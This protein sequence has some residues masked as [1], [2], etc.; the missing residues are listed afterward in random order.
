MALKC[1][2]V[3]NE[4]KAPTEVKNGE[5]RIL[6]RDE[7]VDAHKQAVAN[8]M[9]CL[10]REE[11]GRVEHY[12]TAHQI[13]TTLENYHEGTK[14]LKSRKIQM[15]V[16]KYEMFKMKPNESII[17]ITNRLG[18]HYELVDINNK[19]LKSLPLDKY[20]ARI[21]SIEEANEDL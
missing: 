20:G 5:E 13:W 21:A 10:S 9:S 17:D 14:Q 12:I 4:W 1:E 16:T 7:W 6:P 11:C 18:K 8:L 2:T 3:M 19:I 15:Y